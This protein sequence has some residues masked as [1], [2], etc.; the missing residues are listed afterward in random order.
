MSCDFGDVIGMPVHSCPTPNLHLEMP[1]HGR[2]DEA[3]YNDNDHS[4][5]E[6]GE[7]HNNNL[8]QLEKKLQKARASIETLNSNLQQLRQRIDEEN[9]SSAVQE[10]VPLLKSLKFVESQES[11]LRSDYNAK[12]FEL[13]AEVCEL[14]R[15]MEAGLESES[16]SERESRVEDLDRLLDESVKK[17]D[18]AKKVN[19]L[20]YKEC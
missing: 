13:E 19:K 5:E 17:L 3:I 6:E 8:Q 16:E 20:L 4:I 12:R 9:A 1:E 15:K 7:G 18:S 14:K 2:D 11:V 10:L